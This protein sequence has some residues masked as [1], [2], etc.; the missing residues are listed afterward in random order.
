MLS[1]KSASSNHFGTRDPLKENNFSTDGVG[2][3]VWFR[4]DLCTLHLLCIYFYY[5]YISSTLN[6]QELASRDWGLL[7]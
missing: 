2:R 5:Y 1:L 6:F 4:N 7:N 3:G